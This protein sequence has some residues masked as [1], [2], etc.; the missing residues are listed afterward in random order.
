[1]LVTSPLEIR[2]PSP[3]ELPTRSPRHGPRPITLASTMSYGTPSRTTQPTL[4]DEPEDERLIPE[5]GPP[6]DETTDLLTDTERAQFDISEYDDRQTDGNDVC[7]IPHAVAKA[8]YRER[9]ALAKMA[10]C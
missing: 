8:V 9:C 10:S 6:D 5:A 3:D 1:M 4:H 7:D 2:S